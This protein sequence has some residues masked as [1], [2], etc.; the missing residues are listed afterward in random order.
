[1][2]YKI[3]YSLQDDSIKIEIDNSRYLLC[4][5]SLRSIYFR[6]PVFLRPTGKAYNVEEQLKRSQWSAF[7]RN[8]IIFDNALWINHPVAIYRAENKLYQLKIAKRCGFSVP[9]THVGNSLPLH[10][11]PEN[12][13]IVKSLDTALFYDGGN[14][15]FTYSTMIDGRELLGAEIAMAPIIL[16]E[17]LQSKTDLRVTVI[18]NHIFSVSITKQGKSLVGDWRKSNKDNLDYKPIEL[19]QIIKEQ[20]MLYMKTLDL[21]FGG[22]DLAQVGDLY[23]FIEVNPTGEWG[24]L[25]SSTGIPIDKAIVEHMAIGETHD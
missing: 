20:I 9:E 24:W 7:I 3:D 4:T 23:Y 13:Y 5:K 6:A 17:Y 1:M 18:G 19:P 10:I 14:E 21:S 2:E 15:M 12:M 11:I 8:L 25:V 16:Q 22:I